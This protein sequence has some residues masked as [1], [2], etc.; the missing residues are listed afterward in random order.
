MPVTCWRMAS[1]TATKRA[2]RKP[3]WNSSRI[4]PVSSAIASLICASSMRAWPRPFTLVSTRRASDS[5][6]LSVSQRGLS[7]TKKSAMKNA[8]AG[9]AA[10][11]NIQRQ[12][13]GPA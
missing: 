5:R 1:A 8:S 6:P 2:P 4:D 3:G 10:E 11:A 9:T 7:G 13:V 12:P